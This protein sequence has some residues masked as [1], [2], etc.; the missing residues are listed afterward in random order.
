MAVID[1]I[2]AKEKN[3]KESL[4]TLRKTLNAKHVACQANPNDWSYITILSFTEQ[5]LKEILDY[6]DSSPA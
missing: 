5:K 2:E 3:I 1:T 6:I 4:D